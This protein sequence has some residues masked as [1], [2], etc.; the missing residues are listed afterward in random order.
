MTFEESIRDKGFVEL[1][2]PFS[3]KPDHGI[4]HT[5]TLLDDDMV[6][7]KYDST[8]KFIDI[9]PIYGVYQQCLACKH[10]KR[11]E[12]TDKFEC[13]AEP[14]IVSIYEAEFLYNMTM[15][16]VFMN[17][18]VKLLDSDEWIGLGRVLSMDK[19]EL[20]PHHYFEMLS[21]CME[22]TDKNMIFNSN[23]NFDFRL[24]AKDN[25]V[26]SF[27]G[28]ILNVDDMEDVLCN[29]LIIVLPKKTVKIQSESSKHI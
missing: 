18:F 22:K 20:T 13:I 12:Y 26:S 28:H 2:I 11:N 4:Y 27:A 7:V 9:C 29:L 24:M 17:L 15:N 23:T 25:V 14:H 6:S 8:L 10:Y 1:F 16:A 21:L 3:N 5:F 19:V